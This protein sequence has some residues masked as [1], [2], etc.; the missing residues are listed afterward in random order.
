MQTGQGDVHRVRTRIQTRQGG[1]R[2]RRFH[3]QDEF[4][5]Y[6]TQTIDRGEGACL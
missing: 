6:A 4:G 3:E 1:H 2:I 5:G